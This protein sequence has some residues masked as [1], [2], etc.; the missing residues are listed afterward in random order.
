MELVF[1]ER[2]EGC[3]TV[4][5]PRGRKQTTRSSTFD[6]VRRLLSTPIQ[7]RRQKNNRCEFSHLRWRS[8]LTWAGLLL[9]RFRGRE[10]EKDNQSLS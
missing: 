9:S 5:T 6:Q 8:P 2:G 10:R 1:V 4:D 3:D 7:M